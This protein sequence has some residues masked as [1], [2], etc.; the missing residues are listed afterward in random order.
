MFVTDAEKSLRPRQEVI[1]VSELG[2]TAL[3]ERYC[4]VQRID[5]AKIE[6]LLKYGSIGSCRDVVV[7]FLEDAGYFRSTS[8][9]IQLYVAMDVYI[10]ARSFTKSI[11]VS[12]KEFVELYGNI[13]DIGN[14]LTTPENT[15]DFFTEMLE[16]CI[17]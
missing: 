12:N 1:G 3:E 4:D 17:R 5:P 15:V 7:D 6:Q 14:K 9:L 2:F 16:Q 11:G 13:D 8:L 10:I